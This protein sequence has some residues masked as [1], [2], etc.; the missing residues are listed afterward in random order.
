V[1]SIF[2][3]F[4]KKQIQLKSEIDYFKLKH[5]DEILKTQLEIQEYT[6]EK[7]S[8]EIHDNISLGLTLA[9]L[10]TTTYLDQEQKDP[11]LLEFSIDLISKSLVD[12]ND[13]SKS[14]DANQLLSHG[15]IKALESEIDVLNKTG[16]FSVDFSIEGDPLYLDA[17][18]DLVLLRIFQEACNNI[19]KHARASTIGLKLRYET[20]HITMLISDDGT[21][22]EL[23]KVLEQ[24]EIRKRS[25][26]QNIKARAKLINAKVDI[27]SSPGEGTSIEILTPIKNNPNGTTNQ[28]SCS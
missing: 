6:F 4:R 16:L 11:K 12:L 1:I 27:R 5:E 22:F 23:K 10:Q 15:L 7:I 9:K 2:F 3:L 21:G 8:K 20:D 28:S 14:M 17:E 24:K 26:L 25:G 13:I 18:S 19:I